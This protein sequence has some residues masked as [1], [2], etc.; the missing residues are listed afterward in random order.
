[1]SISSRRIVTLSASSSVITC[2][3]RARFSSVF[4][5]VL[6]LQIV[7]VGVLLEIINFGG[8]GERGILNIEN[9]RNV[10]YLPEKCTAYGIFQ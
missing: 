1:M 3:A 6:Y 4:S 9:L 10:E 8:G 7:L 5:F 2:S